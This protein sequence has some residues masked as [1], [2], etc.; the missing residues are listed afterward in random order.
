MYII[1]KNWR[2]TCKYEG[3]NYNRNKNIICNLL[4]YKI[5]W[6]N[7]NHHHHYKRVPTVRIRP[8]SLSLSLSLPLSL[9]LSLSNRTYQSLH[10]VNF[11]DDTQYLHRTDEC[12]FLLV[13]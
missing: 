7:H 9:S 10:L 1:H 8:F 4:L 5:Q 2:L 12:K 11:Q 13:S 6:E 3:V